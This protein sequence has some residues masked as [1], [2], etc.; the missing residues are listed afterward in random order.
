MLICAL[1]EMLLHSA[2]KG[3]NQR[4]HLSVEHLHVDA[5]IEDMFILNSTCR[6]LFSTL[7][8]LCIIKSFFVSIRI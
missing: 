6:R 3:P 2:I 1:S 8:L 7:L 4:I 5:C